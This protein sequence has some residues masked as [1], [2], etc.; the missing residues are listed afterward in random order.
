MLNNKKIFDK[1]AL[2]IHKVRS[3]F[4]EPAD[5]VDEFAIDQASERLLDINRAFKY[6][7]IVGGNAS[8]WAKSLGLNNA[9]LI[10]DDNHLNFNNKKFDLIIHA[11]SLHWH[12]DPVGQ[13]IQ[14]RQALK[15]DGLMLALFFGGDTLHELRA[16]FEE[17]EL[18]MENGISPRVAPMIE[19]RDAGNLLVRSGFALSVADKTDLEVIYGTPLNLLHDLRRMG[20]T[21]IMINRRKNFLK[22]GTLNRLFEIY[23][24]KFKSSK[25]NRGVKAT[26][27][28][29][30]LTGW[31]PS[32]NQQKPSRRGSATHSFSEVLSTYKL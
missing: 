19:I 1:K 7:S 25:E 14:V 9:L 23:S 29:I 26:F 13:L 2:K 20:E 10:N 22:R 15:P 8:F 31:A 21:N 30:C 28:L 32:A 17:A 27:Q 6:P 4:L 11:L 12:D 5:F 24:N 3:S 16:A 18:T